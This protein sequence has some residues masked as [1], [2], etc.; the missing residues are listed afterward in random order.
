MLNSDDSTWDDRY[1]QYRYDASHRLELVFPPD[2]VER[3][4]DDNSNIATPGDILTKADS[5]STGGSA[6]VSAFASHSYTYYTSDLNTDNAVTTPWGS[7]DLEAK[8]GGLNVNE[9]SFVETEIRNGSCGSCGGGGGGGVKHT[10]FYLLLNQGANPG[11]HEVVGIIVED[12]EDAQG[13]EAFRRIYGLN[14][15]AGRELREAF[16]E[17]P[18]DFTQNVWCHSTTLV[19]SGGAINRV[20]QSRLPSAHAGEVE[21]DDDIE[22]FLDPGSGSND[23]LT[24]N[25]SGDGGNVLQSYTVKPSRAAATAG[26]PTGLSAGTGQSHYLSLTRNGHDAVDGMLLQ[27]DTYHDIPSSGDGTLSTNF[28][29][30]IHQYDDLGRE[31]YT[32]QIASGTGTSNGVEQVTKRIYDVLGR[33]VEVQRGVSGAGHNMGSSY[34]TYPTL[35]KVSAT[36]FDAGG[37]GDGQVTKTRSYYG[38]GA[39]DYTG[40]NSHLTFRGQLRGVEPFNALTPAAAARPRSARSRSRTSTGRG[41]SPPRRSTTRIPPGARSSRTSI[42]PPPSRPTGARLSGPS[43]TTSGAV[44]RPRPGR[45]TPVRVPP[46]TSSRVTPST[47]GTRAS[48]SPGRSTGPRPRPPSTAPGGSTRVARSA[49]RR[50]RPTQAA[51]SSTETPSRTRA[52]PA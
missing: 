11:V 3:L 20:D 17:D 51:P 2:A 1:T 49:A 23:N 36:V 31:G 26:K 52:S 9:I 22:M 37:I 46:G 28:Y 12:T 25:S 7:Q 21:T 27:V 24:M 15:T 32:I 19:T 13:I 47:T 10:Y 38:T 34:T 39:N 5:Y 50:P 45:S 29:R 41:T 18:T 43:T 14:P 48:S 4:I 33:V 16:I 40:M 42:T 30:T 35:D 44:S 8:Y 6:A